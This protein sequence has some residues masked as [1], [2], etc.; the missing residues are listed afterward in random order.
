VCLGCGL[1]CDGT[2]LT[3]LA[4]ADESD[5][6]APLKAL[7]VEVIVE[8][9]PPVFALPCPA[10]VGGECGVYDLHRPG[11]CEQFE[12]ALVRAVASRSLSVEEARSVVADTLE[13]RDRVNAGLDGDDALDRRITTW[14]RR[15]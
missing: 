4:V 3:H 5:L 11:A 2:L 8:A 7:G 12:C 10:A 9:D 15:R 6:G 1:C 14:F 13:L